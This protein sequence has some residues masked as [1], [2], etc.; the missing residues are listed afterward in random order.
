M[1]SKSLKIQG[2]PGSDF[3]RRQTFTK[4]E[5]ELIRLLEDSSD[6][7]LMRKYSKEKTVKDFLDK[8]KPETLEKFV[9]PAIEIFS[10]RIVPLAKKTGIG[11]YLRS[12]LARIVFYPEQKI[13]L[14]TVET[15]CLFNFIK[16]DSGLRYFITLTNGDLEVPLKNKLEIVISSE[17]P[18]IILTNNILHTIEDIDA[19]RLAP[20]YTKSY[21]AVPP[22]MEQKY[23]Q[24][25]VLKMFLQYPVKMMGIDVVHT[26]PKQQALLSLEEDFHG[27]LHF[28]LM[29]MYD[30]HQV[31]PSSKKKKMAWLNPNNVFQI[32]CY[33]RDFEWEHECFNQLTAAGLIRKGDERLYF[34]EEK[35]ADPS[36]K[37]I[38]WIN[39]H[40][41]VLANFVVQQNTSRKYYIQAIQL[42]ASCGEK[43]DWF[44]VNITVAV[45]NY[46]IPFVRFR[47]NI[48][49]GN[50]EY[51]L[52]DD[53]V[54]VLPEEWFARYQEFFQ[55]GE[56]DGEHI[57]LKKMYFGLLDRIF[58][59][60]GTPVMQVRPTEYHSSGVLIP[61]S[62]DKVLRPYQKAG[63]YW[64]LHLYHN[65]FGGCLA[66]DMGLG[67]TLQTT[68][69]LQYIYE[70]SM[71]QKT[72][73]FG[74][75]QLSLF[76]ED[77]FASCLPASLVVVPTS[78]LH[79]WKI[80]LQRFSPGLK[81]YL[82]A[83]NDRYRTKDIGRI[84]RHY[85][86]VI[87]SYGILRKNIEF[88]QHYVFHYLI[89]DESQYVK[90]ADSQTYRSVKQVQ[91]GHRLILT[92]TPIENALSDLWAQFNFINEGLLGNES[93]FQKTYIKP[94]LKNE[95]KT[96]EERLLCLIRPFILR[97]TKEEVTP[98]LPPLSQ[99]IVYCDMS[100]MQQK[101]YETEKNSLRNSI[102]STT[103]QW[104]EKNK[105]I[106][107]QGLMRL[108]LLA[109]HP[110]LV[111]PAYDG[112][113]GKYE[114][115]L[116]SFESLRAGGHKV[117]IFSSFVK[118]LKLIAREFDKQHWKYA[119]L[120][121]Q[122]SSKDREKE[123]A[124]FTDTPD[125]NCFFISLK[126]GG[127]GLNLM[128]AD[129]VFIIDPWWNPAAELQALS[130]AHRIGQEK[131][132]IAYRFI[133]TETIEEK[134]LRLQERKLQ[135]SSAFIF[136]T[137]PMD[138]LSTEEIRKLFE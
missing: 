20:F 130:R 59:E 128:A 86:V 56:K 1:S 37:L 83:G 121:G 9:R 73:S 23:M 87:T 92:G 123:I 74:S 90:N 122:I 97:R 99:E 53:T 47:K 98:D 76:E 66:D 21:I 91:A 84:F 96:A 24:D 132:V 13:Y 44:D 82:Y 125:I 101:A 46:M 12:D 78:L 118:H 8:L 60:E 72:A 124:R 81:T 113:S 108:R 138:N 41:T 112:D 27:Y 42:R 71:Q 35:D 43:Q 16:D 11:I 63:F 36:L 88:L 106:A 111:H 69:L 22:A 129:Y 133:S 49:S 109:N 119:M 89:L 25:F 28:H 51:L 52:P 114:Q 68:A 55:Y 127:S 75:G 38:A 79:N 40:Q 85:Q 102:L 70:G 100:E 67:K 33:E 104:L 65:H 4:D 10:S 58:S 18:A 19:K 77:A 14:P 5:Q 39:A 117:L 110:S 2:P 80:E 120:T 50:R 15:R 137:N 48:L 26:H 31:Y 134:M 135:L 32:C 30:S 6:S 103:G 94:I 62:L 107:L 64:L 54:F 95:D 116:L 136:A 115:I 17:R 126:A 7:A 3:L 45:G 131:N 57:R 61:A 105:F 93:F 29:F 34:P